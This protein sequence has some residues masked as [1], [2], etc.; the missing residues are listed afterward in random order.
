MDDEISP[1][2][3]VNTLFVIAGA[4]HPKAK[5]DPSLC[6]VDALQYSRIG[7]Y[8]RIKQYNSLETS[9]SMINTRNI[10]HHKTKEEK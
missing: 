7:K 3:I 5:I 4:L 6:N 10:M 9:G 2:V 1:K 8:Q